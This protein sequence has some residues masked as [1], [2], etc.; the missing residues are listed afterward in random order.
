MYLSS[1]LPP[2]STTGPRRVTAEVTAAAD[3][4]EW[5]TRSPVS[6]AARR[7]H[8][9]RPGRRQQAAQPVRLYACGGD[10]TLNEVVNGAAGHPNAAVTHYAGGSG[11]D[12][13]QYF[14]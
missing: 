9:H 13:V 3:R 5:T 12:F 11:N 4:R 10:G 14:L 7:L 8:T 6:I 2:E 1:T